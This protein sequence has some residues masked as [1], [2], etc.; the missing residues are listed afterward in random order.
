MKQGNGFYL[1]LNSGEDF[2]IS[3]SCVYIAK[4]KNF[5]ISLMLGWLTVAIGYEF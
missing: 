3:L 2:G 1:T 4:E 5:Q